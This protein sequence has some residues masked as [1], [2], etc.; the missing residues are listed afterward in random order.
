MKCI[1]EDIN[2]KGVHF[3]S[4]ECEIPNVKNLDDI[5]EEKLIGYITD[6][7]EQTIK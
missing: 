7:L 1:L 4:Y 5:P 2:Y 3:D 6:S